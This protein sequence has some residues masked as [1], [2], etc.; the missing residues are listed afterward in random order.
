MKHGASIFQGVVWIL[1]VP[2][3]H[4][5]QTK[6]RPNT[7]KSSRDA[8]PCILT[9]ASNT[10][11]A[12]TIPFITGT[13]LLL[14]SVGSDYPRV[15]SEWM[16]LGLPKFGNEMPRNIS[17]NTPKSKAQDKSDGNG[18]SEKEVEHGI[19]VSGLVVY[20]KNKMSFVQNII[21]GFGSGSTQFKVFVHTRQ[22][23]R[24]IL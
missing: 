12:V 9:V 21:F 24:D 10:E 20:Y 8:H 11:S 5:C 18:G 13:T 6:S 17:Q 14:S 1:R 2:A 7:Q 19:N 3:F 16:S 15:T 23:D 4:P 22:I